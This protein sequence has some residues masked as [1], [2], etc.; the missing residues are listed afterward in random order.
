[1]NRAGQYRRSGVGGAGAVTAVIPTYNRRDLVVQSA[2]TVLS[3][4]YP[5][6]ECLVVDNG[7]SDGT[8]DA[9]RALGAER[10]AVVERNTPLG[11]ARAR[12]IGIEAARTPW[13]A[14]LD[15]DDLWAPTKIELQLQTLAGY[16]S[17]GWCATACAYV[18]GDLTMR[19]GGRL[20]DG[21]LGPERGELLSSPELLALLSRDNIVPGG[22]SSVLT[23]REMVLAAGGFH[24]D[25]PGCEDW[26]LW[27][28]LARLSPMT[29]LDRPLAAWRIWEGQGS[30]DARMMLR[31]ANRVRSKYFPEL[32]PLER[33]YAQVWYGKAARRHLSEKHR[34]R[35]SE[36]FLELARIGRAPGQLAY[37]VAALMVPSLTERRLDRVGPAEPQPDQQWRELAEPWLR[38]LAAFRGPPKPAET[39]GLCT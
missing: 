10:L 28:R 16:P 4:T 5:E 22:G 6:V 19:P 1:M 27:V 3:Q 31:S 9:L 39:S 11:A 25:V 24:N 23:A 2:R 36:Q 17:A 26:D 8:A 34:V 21:P 12:N 38:D 7:P 20:S 14:F 15:N 30:T 13:I 29:Y 35:A 37:A 18:G 32:G 33:Q